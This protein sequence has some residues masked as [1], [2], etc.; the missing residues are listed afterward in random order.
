MNMDRTQARKLRIAIFGGS[1]NPP[2]IGHVAICRYVADHH[3]ADQIL[4]VP[5]FEH[6]FGKPLAAYD[7]RF[8]MCR[9]AFA[10]LPRAEISS[11]EQEL[12]GVSYTARTVRALQSRV[13]D[14]ALSLVIGE[15]SENDLAQWREGAWLQQHVSLIRIPRGPHSPIPD[16]SASAIRDRLREGADITTWIPS[17]VIAYIAQHHLYLQKTPHCHPERSEGSL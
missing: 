3:L 7:H 6:P 8:A 5:C 4:V 15:G 13:P 16:I 12:G 10:D 1:F 14:A 11:I 2:H 9:L 17:T